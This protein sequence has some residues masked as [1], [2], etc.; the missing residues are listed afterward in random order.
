MGRGKKKAE[1]R[2][3]GHVTKD[4]DTAVMKGEG[5]LKWN[6]RRRLFKIYVTLGNKGEGFDDAVVQP[7]LLR[8]L[9]LIPSMR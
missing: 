7:T 3:T 5:R 1:E 6:I 4:P 8:V 2:E 9:D